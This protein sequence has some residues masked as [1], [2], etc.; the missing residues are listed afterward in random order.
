MKL[1]KIP[2]KNEFTLSGLTLGKLLAIE[3]YLNAQN[4]LSAPAQD[5]SDFLK[6]QDLSNIN[7][8][9]QSHHL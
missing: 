1:I 9:T 7:I 8:N 2:G 6:S 4:Q 3:R 5:V